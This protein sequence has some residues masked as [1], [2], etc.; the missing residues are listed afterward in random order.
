M[1]PTPP[2]RPLPGAA[3]PGGMEL[4][5]LVPFF[6]FVL[7]LFV[8]FCLLVGIV[9]VGESSLSYVPFNVFDPLAKTLV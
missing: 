7:F 3:L 4:R 2:P 6:G 8:W 1:L 5:K 9:A